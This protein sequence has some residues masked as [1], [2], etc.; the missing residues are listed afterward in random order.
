MN[1]GTV[2]GT[3]TFKDDLSAAWDRAISTLE[4][5][6]SKL[7]SSLDKLATRI[8]AVKPKTEKVKDDTDK[9]T[10]AYARLSAQLDPTA[11]RTQKYESAVSVL[12]SALKRGLITQDAYNQRLQ[13]AKDRLNDTSAAQRRHQQDLDKTRVA[14]VKV[15]ASLDPATAKSQKYTQTLATL[16]AALAKGIINQEEFNKRVKQLSASLDPSIKKL[17]RFSTIASDLGRNLTVLTLPLA[18]LG[19]YSVKSAIEF[20]SSFAGVNKTVD[21]LTD[22][23]GNLTAE[24]AKLQQGLRD[25]AAGENPIPIDIDELNGVAEA[26]GQL[27]IARDDILAFTRTMADLGET[28]NLAAQEAATATAQFQNIFGAAGVDVDRFGSAL[29]AL[30]NAGA[31][32]EK[33]IIEMGVRIAGAGNQIGLTQGEVLAF[34]SALSSVGI[35]AEAGGSAISK[36]MIDMAVSVAQGGRELHNFSQVAGMTTA[37]FKEAFEKDAAGAVRTFIEGLAKIDESGG[38]VLSVLEKMGISEVRMRDAL[39][40]AAGA[41]DLLRDSLDLQAKAWQE[42]SALTD[43]AKKRYQ[44]FESQLKI[45]VQ[46]FKD[47]AITLGT[48]MLPVLQKVLDAATPII[49]AFA[50]MAESFADLPGPIKAITIAMGGLLAATGPTV[51]VAGQL[52]SSWVTL[53]T[54]APGLAAAISAVNVK[55]IAQ[56]AVVAGLLLAINALISKWKEALS[57]AIQYEVETG[58]L[59]GRALQFAQRHRDGAK[60]TSEV[61][62]QA[63]KDLT[64]LSTK[65]QA[66]QGHV[67]KLNKIIKEGNPDQAY[68]ASEQL[69]DAER[70][71]RNVKGAHDRLAMSLKGVTVET[72]KTGD[73]TKGLGLNLNILGE[74]SDKAARKAEKL[75]SQLAELQAQ[76]EEQARFLRAQQSIA[77]LGPGTDQQYVYEQL[78]NINEEHEY[79]LDLL[80]KIQQYGVQ[81]GTDLA[82]TDRELKKLEKDIDLKFKLQFIN[83]K[84]Q[85]PEL[86]SGIIDLFGGVQDAIDQGMNDLLA[87]LSELSREQALDI[88]AGRSTDPVQQANDEMYAALLTENR[89]FW[90]DYSDEVRDG[91]KS[92]SDRI[93]DEMDKVRAA[94]ESGVEGALTAAEAEKELGR[95]RDQ[96]A[97]ET[98]NS[99]SHALGVL[100]DKFGGFFNY[101]SQA[102]SAIQQG[103]SFGS[104]VGSIVQGLG[105]GGTVNPSGFGGTGAAGAAAGVASVAYVWY[106]VYDTVDKIIKDS[107]TRNYGNVAELGIVN[108]REGITNLDKQSGELVKSIRETIQSLEDAL[109]ISVEDLAEIGIKVRNDGKHVKAYVKGELIGKFGSVDEA[110]GEALRLALKDSTTNLQGLSDLMREGLSSYSVPDFEGLTDFLQSLREISDLDLSPGAIQIQQT[111]RHLDDLF[112]TLER[113]PS[114]AAV[115]Q[116]MT[117]IVTGEI[118]A[119]LSWRRAIT[120]EQE[121]PADIRARQEREVAMFKAEKAMRIAELKLREI[122]LKMEAERVRLRGRFVLG[123]AN[124]NNR[125]LENEAAYLNA[126][127]KLVTTEGDLFAAQLTAIDL[128]LN[129]IADLIAQLEDIPDIDLGSLKP[130][131]RGAGAGGSDVGGVQS[132]IDDRTFDLALRVMGEYEQQVATITRQYEEQIRQTRVDSRERA[133]LIALREREIDLLRREQ[134]RTVADSFTVFV[135]GSD[136]FD[137]IRQTA[138][139]LIQQIEDSPFG[140][141]RKARMIG[142]VMAAVD[143]QIERMAN[144]SARGLFGSLITD[145]EKYGASAEV[146]S[147]ARLQMEI[148]EHTIKMANYAVEIEALRAQGKIPAQIMKVMDDAFKFLEGV[149]V[150]KWLA[151][152]G[153][154]GA[155]AGGSQPLTPTGQDLRDALAERQRQE[156]EALAEALKRARESLK[157]YQHDGVDPFTRELME[158]RDDFAEIRRVMGNTPEVLATFNDAIDRVVDEYLEPIAESQRDLFYGDLSTADTVD[159][160]AKIQQERDEIM[161]KF[162]AGDLSVL[163]RLPEFGEQYLAL[164]E[165]M[166]PKS[167]QGYKGHA[168][169]WDAFLSQ[170]QLQAPQIATSA[171]LGSSSTPMNVAGMS[172]IARYS[173]MQVDRLEMVNYTNQQVLGQLQLLNG[174]VQYPS[175]GGLTG[176]H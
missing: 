133:Q 46:R 173:E 149:D 47:A 35:E 42:N 148:L 25:L 27:G 171:V 34:A 65:L 132:F 14:Y 18:A 116:G 16:S 11:G 54:N 68:L 81:I 86:R 102:V 154:A 104:S 174:K 85:I 73:S 108:F 95:L 94:M 163:D 60:V 30:G 172:E 90:Q 135:N 98:I 50:A 12:D 88:L 145:L 70:N 97:V 147:Q 2:S 136:Q 48:G 146:I 7:Q 100:A 168:S 52:V 77:D 122:D 137:Q 20:E 36:V 79:R 127:A 92:T 158:V 110:I 87:H 38:S 24:G 76:Q 1:V 141:E 165:L 103:G 71:L 112:R 26:A 138:E 17:E 119:W 67:A 45:T 131:G 169:I 59:E 134:G 58:N 41:G 166:S 51:F 72:K 129:A 114:S 89:E 43:E 107:K 124:I 64:D 118:D 159:Q 5:S 128:A 121:S 162:A 63:T 84:G 75:T 49:S 66:A 150:T 175:Q 74:E 82:N 155:G 164:A 61:Y 13:Q 83:P 15:V 105:G 106:M 157:K 151:A 115:L 143:E 96:L 99:W 126:K 139:D 69:V 39:L 29:V 111:I 56:G 123:N 176:V 55:L 19:A 78:Q 153:G 93:R 9:L 33:Q 120:G 170:V 160:W 53:T 167:S 101:L 161:S 22:A 8:D 140:N 3:L 10:I 113:M 80:A 21:G 130:P 40:R 156:A 37:Q 144:E 91:W 28:T 117:S 23:L 44:T 31:S 109:R 142:R 152:T 125:D 4:S 6:S 32:T 57:A 62:T